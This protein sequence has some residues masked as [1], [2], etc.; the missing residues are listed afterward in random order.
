LPSRKIKVSSAYCILIIP[1]GQKDLNI[2]TTKLLFAA[3][4]S[5]RVNTSA[6]KLNRIGEIGSP[7]LTP[8]LVS[9]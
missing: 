4:I 7:C 5:I 2:P 6:T 8:L 1:E 9:K 3:L